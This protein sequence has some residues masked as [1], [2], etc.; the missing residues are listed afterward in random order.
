MTVDADALRAHV[1]T[2]LAR[3]KVPARVTVVESLPRSP[4][5]KL[6]RRALTESA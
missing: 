6:L 1:G 4:A 5:G 3:Y 2:R